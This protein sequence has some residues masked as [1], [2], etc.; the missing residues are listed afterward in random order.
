MKPQVKVGWPFTDA[1]VSEW[2][3][4]VYG[5]VFEWGNQFD[6]E[7]YRARYA[8]AYGL[9]HTNPIEFLTPPVRT[10]PEPPTTIEELLD[11]IGDRVDDSITP[12]ISDLRDMLK[13]VI[14]DAKAWREC[15][16]ANLVESYDIA[17]ENEM[18]R[19]IAGDGWMRNEGD[20]SGPPI[21]CR[22]EVV[23]RDGSRE[24]DRVENFSWDHIQ[25][26][27]D[28]IAYRSIE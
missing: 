5:K 28:I 13:Q 10:R 18:L 16:E 20:I 17:V 12:L 2:L 27:S 1:D 19:L 8:E 22:V 3:A 23:L 26:T 4:R 6:Q 25:H 14:A 15:N 9:K 7:A 21:E 11:D 24:V